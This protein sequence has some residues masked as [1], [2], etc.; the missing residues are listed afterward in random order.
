M[1]KSHEAMLIMNQRWMEGRNRILLCIPN[2]D[3]LV[4]WT[5]LLERHYSVPYVTMTSRNDWANHTDDEHPNGFE[6]E[7]IVIT[8]DDFAAE[9]EAEASAVAWDLVVFEEAN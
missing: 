8:T 6:Q 3:L 9:H 7:G 4:Q 5:D 1:G 2:A